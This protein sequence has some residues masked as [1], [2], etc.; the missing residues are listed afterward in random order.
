M[1]FFKEAS[2]F[3]NWEIRE[4]GRRRAT[5]ATIGTKDMH[6]GAKAAAPAAAL[7][8]LSLLL[9]LDDYVDGI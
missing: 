8:Q 4:R 2:N 3:F 7:L 9:R 6:A 1:L 5:E